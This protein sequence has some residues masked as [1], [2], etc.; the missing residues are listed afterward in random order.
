MLNSI[1][2][3]NINSQVL[4]ERAVLFALESHLAMIEF[5]PYGEVIWVNENFSKAMGYETRE[6]KGMK[7]KQFCTKEFSSSP[8]Y[9][10]LW[11]NLRKGIK[12]QE[13]IQ[14]V[15]K[16]GNI[17]WLEATYIPIL[18]DTGKVEA[19]LKIAT[20]ITERENKG[21][22]IVSDLNSMSINLGEVV[23]TKSKENI[24]ALQILNE[25]T[26][27]VRDISQSIRYISSQTNLLALNA[28]IEAARAG[29]HGRGFSVVAEEVRRLANNV[30]DAI[31]NIDTNIKSMTEGVTK[32]NEVTKGLQ[33]TVGEVQ[34]KITKTMEEFKSIK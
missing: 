29:E 23:K 3:M 24:E 15:G 28:S 19:V 8:G 13:K 1:S 32:V 11:E 12:S 9:T 16:K 30:D 27:N 5:N 20:D 34:G 4:E 25:Q 21:V 17:L 6:M 10:L 26:Q 22:E 7:H 14:R 33:Q 18:N 31:K 2:S